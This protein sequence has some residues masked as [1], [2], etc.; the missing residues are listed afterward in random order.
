MKVK[1]HL[2]PSTSNTSADTCSRNEIAISLS[3]KYDDGIKLGRVKPRWLKVMK[4][5]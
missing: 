3:L 5:I 4:F 2:V 1:T